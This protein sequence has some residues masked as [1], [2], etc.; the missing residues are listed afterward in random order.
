MLAN[1]HQHTDQLKMQGSMLFPA[2]SLGNYCGLATKCDAVHPGH[3][4]YRANY[5]M[6]LDSLR[7]PELVEIH[8]QKTIK[9]ANGMDT[10]LKIY[11]L[12]HP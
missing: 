8:F 6:E 9:T 1:V 5:E 7:A 2:S 4:W 10:I 11:L 12:A 3:H